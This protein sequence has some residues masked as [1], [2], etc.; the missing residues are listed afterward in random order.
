MTEWQT[1]S[2]H[3]CDTLRL[4]TSGYGTQGLDWIVSADTDSTTSMEARPRAGRVIHS[5]VPQGHGK[6]D[7]DRIQVRCEICLFAPMF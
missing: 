3:G 4:N 5:A 2:H 1:L 6:F 7:V